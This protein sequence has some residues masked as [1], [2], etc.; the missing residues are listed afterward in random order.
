M[1]ACVRM[2]G[3]KGKIPFGISHDPF[4]A[5][6][7]KATKTLFGLFKFGHVI[8]DK[9]TLLKFWCRTIW[10]VRAWGPRGYLQGCP[11]ETASSLGSST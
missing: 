6:L 3:T 2:R 11:G 7:P 1:C 9:N 8:E 4:P 5:L 10:L